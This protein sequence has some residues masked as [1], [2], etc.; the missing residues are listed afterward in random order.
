[1]PIRQW[2]TIFPRRIRYHRAPGP[3]PATLALR[4][5][6]GRE[7]VARRAWSVD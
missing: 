4:A 5:V 3:K 7:E 1:M 2:V 6:G